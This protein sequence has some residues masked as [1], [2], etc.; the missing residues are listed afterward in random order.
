MIT[1]YDK[2]VFL[3]DF[4]KITG[5]HLTVL[6][7]RWEGVLEHLKTANI[8]PFEYLVYLHSTGLPLEGNIIN[9]PKYI[10][11]YLDS[12]PKRK[13]ENKDKLSWFIDQVNCRYQ[14][15]HTTKEILE[16]K[17][18]DCYYIFKYVLSTLNNNT[19]YMNQFRKAAL[20]ELSSMPELRGLVSKVYGKEVL[21]C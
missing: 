18:L 5:K 11:K 7:G 15:G 6:K 10:K 17:Q 8:T 2:E 12:L 16:D 4:L 3:D 1:N 9:S 14:T 13:K 20:Y 21:P 19:E